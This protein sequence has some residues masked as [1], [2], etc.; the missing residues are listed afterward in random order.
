MQPRFSERRA[1]ARRPAQFAL[2]IVSAAKCRLGIGRD[3]SDRGMRLASHGR[4]EVGD[5]VSVRYR[6]EEGEYRTLSGVVVRYRFDDQADFWMH[7]VA[8]AF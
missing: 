1:A 2:E 8:V 3:E 7:E 6:D 4:F 5:E